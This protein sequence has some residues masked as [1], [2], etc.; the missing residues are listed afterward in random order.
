MQVHTVFNM[1]LL[2]NRRL[3]V[4]MTLANRFASNVGQEIIAI[5]EKLAREI[6]QKCIECNDLVEIVPDGVFV[7]VQADCIV[8]TSEEL[9]DLMRKQ[10]KAGLEHAHGFMP[11][12]E[13]GSV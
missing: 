7:K 12:Y 5:R 10:F 1:D 2:P 11:V 3:I 13:K 4:Q 8:M 6:A 9:A